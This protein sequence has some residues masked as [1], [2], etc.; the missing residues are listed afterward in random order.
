MQSYLAAGTIVV[1]TVVSFVIMRPLL[2]R[3]WKDSK[4]DPRA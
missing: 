2:C 4:Y 3:A 1:S